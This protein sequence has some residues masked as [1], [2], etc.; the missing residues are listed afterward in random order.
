MGTI[1]RKVTILSLTLFAILTGSEL[2]A[3]NR[4]S[5]VAKRLV[6]LPLRFE[7]NLGQTDRSVDFIS[8]GPGYTLFLKSN[9]AVLAFEN[10]NHLR[11]KL[12]GALKGIGHAM[13]PLSTRSNYLYGNRNSW[14]TNLQN[15]GRIRYESI[16]E[17]IDLVYYGKEHELEYDFIVAPKADPRQIRLSFEGVKKRI[18][19][20]G[21]L[22]LYTEAGIV[23]LQKPVTY[24]IKAGRREI[25]RSS[26]KI[27]GE[28]IGF[29]LGTYNRD[30]PLII[31]PVLSYSTLLGG[32]GFD[33]GLDIVSDA[34]G[35]AYITGLTSSLNF[36]ASTLDGTKQIPDSYNAFVAKLNPSGTALE[37]ATYIGGES[38]DEATG[39]SLSNTGE[40]YLTGRT[41]SSDFPVS[42]NAFQKLFSKGTCN[43]NAVTI[44]CSDLFVMRLN[45]LANGIIYSTL[46]GGNSMDVSNDIQVDNLGNAYITGHTS[47]DDYPVSSNSLKKKRESIDSFVTKIDPTGSYLIFSTLLGGDLDDYSYSLAIGDDESVY[48]TGRTHSH[49]YPTTEGAYQREATGFGDGFISRLKSDGGSL[50]YSTYIRGTVCTS[51]ALDYEKNAYVTGAANSLFVPRPGSYKSHSSGIDAFLLKL[52]PG[53]SDAIFSTFIGGSWNEIATSIKLDGAGRIYL[54]GR[55]SSQDF[56]TTGNQTRYGGGSSDA[57][58]TVMNSAATNLLFSTY[59]GGNFD[60]QGNSVAL[61]SSGNIFVAGQTRPGPKPTPTPREAPSPP[62]VSPPAPPAPSPTPGPNPSG[63]PILP[64]GEVSFEDLFGDFFLLAS[65][66]EKSLAAPSPT[67]ANSFPTTSGAVQPRSMG[68]SEAFVA[69][70]SSLP[71]VT[72]SV[73]GKITNGKGKGLVGI[74]VLLKGSRLESTVTD[75]AGHFSFESVEGGVSYTL[76]LEERAEPREHR[77]T[78]TADKSADFVLQENGCIQST[79]QI[80][81]VISNKESQEL[82][83][84][85]K[86]RVQR[87]GFTLVLKD[88]SQLKA[89]DLHKAS[90]LI[91]SSSVN[92]SSINSRFRDI[93]VPVLTWE[94]RLFDDLGMTKSKMGRDYGVSGKETTFQITSGHPIANGLTGTVKVLRQP[95]NLTWGRPSNG[96]ITVG[97]LKGTQK[98]SALFAYEKGSQM[99]GIKAPERRVG[100]F[101]DPDASELLTPDAWRLFDSALNWAM[102]INTPCS[103]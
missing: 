26:Y 15:Y 94:N 90:L 38:Y 3:S 101:L 72:Y 62:K 97:S 102:R 22:L 48:L 61:D 1:A 93:A 4:S 84:L 63:W 73:K 78:L 34:T 11:M 96:A 69:R 25:V 51:I 21:N 77:F 13:D 31:D 76:Y 28:N 12:V 86:A 89:S 16:Y 17:G 47:S 5:D 53:G 24:Q 44:P 74:K 50:V 55:T 14:K 9:E 79:K 95:G 82:D 39:I 88:D 60:D 67:P 81:F 91:I 83:Q 19:R 58:L 29:Q 54:T 2:L 92:S 59:L 6:K 43:Q 32:S 99:V 30:L 68:Q 71:T 65:V 40:I 23:E 27:T 64:R 35:A 46:I 85:V 20:K 8:R 37:F 10:Q 66:D 100:L 41:F 70:F 45:S 7:K 36:P 49:N 103:H 57:F 52:N 42:D 18:D 75:A 56:P 33:E 98:R 80:L 87:A